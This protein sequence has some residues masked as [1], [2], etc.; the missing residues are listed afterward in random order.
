MNQMLEDDDF[1]FSS[2]DG[3]TSKAFSNL[4]RYTQNGERSSVSNLTNVNEEEK[5]FA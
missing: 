1:L 4:D 3:R 2:H 5:V